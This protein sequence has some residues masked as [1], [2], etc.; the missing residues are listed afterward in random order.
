MVEIVLT[1]DDLLMDY[2]YQWE[3]PVIEISPA[4]S[5]KAADRSQQR[6]KISL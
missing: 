4:C 3:W 1:L 5:V 2:R 6:Y